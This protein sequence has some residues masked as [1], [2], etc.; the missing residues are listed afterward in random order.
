MT[1]PAAELRNAIARLKPPTPDFGARAL[2][3]FEGRY[4]ADVLANW[5]RRIALLIEADNLAF[6]VALRLE[7]RVPEGRR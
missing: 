6:D 3:G 5:F 4:K 7:A 2:F 1:R